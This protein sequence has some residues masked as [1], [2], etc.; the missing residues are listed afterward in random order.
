[1][2]QVLCDTSVFLALW[3]PGEKSSHQIFSRKFFEDA[4]KCTY[5]INALN[6]SI[7]EIQ[8]KFPFI[9]NDYIGL[10][11]SFLDLKKFEEFQIGDEKEILGLFNEAKRNGMNLSFND[12]ALLHA[13]K[14]K[15]FLLLSW[16]NKLVEFAAEMQKIMAKRPDEL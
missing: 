7:D 2:Q 10:C 3:A 5:G 9:L 14:K 6:V 16:D 15:G 11:K 12:C 1:M 8:R 13:A 4:K